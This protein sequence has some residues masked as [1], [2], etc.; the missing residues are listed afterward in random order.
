MYASAAV[1]RSNITAHASR[2][3]LPSPQAAVITPP[4]LIGTDAS[5]VPSMNSRIVIF[6]VLLSGSCQSLMLRHTAEMRGAR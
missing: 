2:A 3:V 5:I 1:I 6:H 4:T